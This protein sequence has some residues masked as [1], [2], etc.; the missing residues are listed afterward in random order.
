MMT[1]ELNWN[2]SFID[3]TQ[4]QRARFLA[5]VC[6]LV[7][8]FLFWLWLWLSISVIPTNTSFAFRLPE[9]G[10]INYICQVRDS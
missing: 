5:V 10:E 6:G 7:G 1:H 2:V 9:L 3:N 8:S 4:Q